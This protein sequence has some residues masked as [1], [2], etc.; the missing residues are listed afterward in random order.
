MVMQPHKLGSVLFQ[1]IAACLIYLPTSLY[2]CSVVRKRWFCAG[3][4]RRAQGTLRALGKGRRGDVWKSQIFFYPFFPSQ[5]ALASSP[6]TRAAALSGAC[7]A[8]AG[9]TAWTAATRGPAVSLCFVLFSFSLW[10]WIWDHSQCGSCGVL[11]IQPLPVGSPSLSSPS[12][13]ER[14]FSYLNLKAPVGLAELDAVELFCYQ[15]K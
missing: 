11:L 7:A 12:Q 13:L 8:T 6:A 1:G 3:C 15:T 4:C 5:P 14:W 10:G 9:W 2:P